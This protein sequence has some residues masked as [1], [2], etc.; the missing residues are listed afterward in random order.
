[1]EKNRTFLN[2]NPNDILYISLNQEGNNIAI[3]T[4]NGF[5][6]LNIYPFLDLYYKD[7]EGGIGTIEMLINQIF[8]FSWRGKNPKYTLNELNVKLNDNKIYIVKKKNFSI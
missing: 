4:E 1:M 3:G 5:K 2:E 7:L 6:I 8:S